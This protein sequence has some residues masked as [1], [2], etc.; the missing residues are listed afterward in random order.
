MSSCQVL[1]SNIYSQMAPY[2]VGNLLAA[3]AR[4]LAAPAVRFLGI[5]FV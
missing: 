5:A 1:R 2:F 4:D 3:R